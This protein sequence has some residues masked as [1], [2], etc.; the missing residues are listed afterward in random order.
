MLISGGNGKKV[1]AVRIGSL[2]LVI[3]APCYHRAVCFEGNVMIAAGR[4]ADKAITGR[5]VCYL[6]VVK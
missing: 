6:T 2:P 5:C 1:V 3:F 4:N